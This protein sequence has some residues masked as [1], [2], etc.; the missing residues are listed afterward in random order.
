MTADT[1]PPRVDHTDTRAQ[2]K[3]DYE[4]VLWLLGAL[5]SVPSLINIVQRQL[6]V[7]LGPAFH[8]MLGFY[9]ELIWNVAS[10]IHFRDWPFLARFDE[11]TMRAIADASPSILLGIGLTARWLTS[12]FPRRVQP[13]AGPLL[14]LA[15]LAWNVGFIY[16]AMLAGRLTRLLSMSTLAIA[17]VPF[18]CLWVSFGIWIFAWAFRGV[19]GEPRSHAI[20]ATVRSSSAVVLVTTAVWIAGLIVFYVGNELSNP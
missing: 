5:F 8:S 12:I 15:I 18:A 2:A 9:R 4:R 17:F 6:K 1:T 14:L 10:A 11:Q 20:R 7:G 16:Y 13:F 3:R 19:I